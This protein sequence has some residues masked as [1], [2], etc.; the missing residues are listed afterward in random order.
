M[1]FRL[2]QAVRSVGLD[3][4]AG[5]TLAL[6]GESVSGKTTLARAI[7]ALQEPS[8]GTVYL[9]GKE[10]RHRNRAFYGQVQRV[11]QNPREALATA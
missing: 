1:S 11:F 7:M 8:G 2:L 9:E 6:V 4:Q 5:E 3:I 10:L